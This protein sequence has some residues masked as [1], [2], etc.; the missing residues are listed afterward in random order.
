MLEMSDEIIITESISIPSSEIEL[1]A[2]RAGGA[3]GQNVNKVSSAVH[4]RFDVAN[5]ASLPEAV[6]ARLLASSDSRISGNGIL[7]IK[8][9]SHRTQE[10]NRQEAIERLQEAIAAAVVEP[11]VRKKTRPGKAVKEKRLA[12]KRKRSRRKQERGP[13]R[14]DD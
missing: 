13:V 6:R 14:S 8:S 12:D 11:K 1:S 5:S 7:V 3:G 10:R 9:Q 4:L 2:I